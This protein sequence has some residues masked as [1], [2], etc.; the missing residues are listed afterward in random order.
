MPERLRKVRSWYGL[1]AEIAVENRLWHLV[2]V[3]GVSLNHPPVINLL[4][5]RNLPDEDRL[6][7]SFLHEYGH[8]QTLPIALLHAALL[9]CRIRRVRGMFGAMKAM[10]TAIVAHEAAWELAAEGNVIVKTGAEY[11]KIYRKNPNP[12]GQALFWTGMATAALLLTTRLAG[13]TRGALPR[14][15]S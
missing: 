3:A 8:L 10:A 2:R 4:L 6:R 13:V 7:L 12:L 15:G 9:V 11:R 14:T 1:Q 5:R